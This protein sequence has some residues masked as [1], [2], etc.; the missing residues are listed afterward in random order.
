MFHL[1]S[2][3][4]VSLQVHRHGAAHPSRLP[5][6]SPTERE[7]LCLQSIVLT[8]PSKTAGKEPPSRFPDRAAMERHPQSLR[9]FS[10]FWKSHLRSAPAC[11]FHSEP[12]WIWSS[13]MYFC[14][15]KC[16]TKYHHADIDT[17]YYAVW[18]YEPIHFLPD[19]LWNFGFQLHALY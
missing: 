14:V 1:Q 16:S 11:Y 8:H 15:V 12:A 10:I 17:Q 4:Y 6:R 2:P 9:E 19:W 3:L 13:K 18:V 5:S 7:T